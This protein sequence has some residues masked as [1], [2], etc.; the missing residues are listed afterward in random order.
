MLVAKQL[1]LYFMS[2]TAGINFPH[3]PFFV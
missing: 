3:V 2:C 1:F